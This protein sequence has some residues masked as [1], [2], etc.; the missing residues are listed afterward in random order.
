MSISAYLA[1]GVN[2]LS[3]YIPTETLSRS[4]EGIGYLAIIPIALV[5]SALSCIARLFTCL[6]P[7][8]ETCARWNMNSSNVFT[9]M[10]Q[11]V[12]EISRSLFCCEPLRVL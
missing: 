6:T 1:M 3:Q 12:A 2:S 9:G 7:L 5:E 11:A 10:T 4:V 8:N